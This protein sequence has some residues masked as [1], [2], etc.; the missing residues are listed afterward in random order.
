MAN[1]VK[2]YIFIE[3][4]VGSTKEVI[5]G[6]KRFN[7]IKSVET[8]TGPYDIIAILEL[9]SL[10]EIGDMVTQNVQKVNGITRTVTC[11]AL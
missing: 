4:N 9:E 3:C 11:I 8:V 7:G 6:L 1:A 5:E 10:P 2:A